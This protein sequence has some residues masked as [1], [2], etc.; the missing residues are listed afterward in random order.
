MF[1]YYFMASKHLYQ[2]RSTCRRQWRVILHLLV[3]LIFWLGVCWDI[4]V[5]PAPWGSPASFP[6]NVLS[7]AMPNANV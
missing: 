6:G 1:P 5:G 2:E 7:D 4:C 3:E